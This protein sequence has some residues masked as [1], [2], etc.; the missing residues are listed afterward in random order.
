MTKKLTQKQKVKRHLI[1]YCSITPLEAL[2]D[3][4]IMRLAAIICDLRKEGWDIK[5]IDTKDK[6]KFG[7]WCHYATYMHGGEG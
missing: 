1:E 3:Y 2:R 6:N 7:E 4:S 5:T